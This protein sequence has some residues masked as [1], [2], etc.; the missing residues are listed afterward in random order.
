MKARNVATGPGLVVG[1]EASRKTPARGNLPA[2]GWMGRS[3]R[4]APRRCRCGNTDLAFQRVGMP[5]PPGQPDTH[6][7]SDVRFRASS[8]LRTCPLPRKSARRP[9][10][11]DFHRHPS[12]AGEISSKPECCCN[13]HYPTLEGKTSEV[14]SV[15]E[16]AQSL[17]SAARSLQ[18]SAAK[19]AKLISRRGAR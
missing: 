15:S 1:F 6:P 13:A 7:K 19:L 14:S 17:H 18:R 8:K 16:V 9:R 11:Y 3:S 4:E 12:R 10:R 2:N 5:V